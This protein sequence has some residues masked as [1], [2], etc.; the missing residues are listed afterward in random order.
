[1]TCPLEG[2][3][4]FSKPNEK[5]LSLSVQMLYAKANKLNGIQLVGLSIEMAP[6]LQFYLSN[7]IANIMS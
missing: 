3:I 2:A 4:L 1:M 7:F 5:K 6:S